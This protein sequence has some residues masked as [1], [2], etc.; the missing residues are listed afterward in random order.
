GSGRPGTRGGVF[1]SD[2]GGRVHR[3]GPTRAPITTPSGPSRGGDGGGQPNRGHRPRRSGGS[4]H[5]RGPRGG[6]PMTLRIGVDV[7]G[8]S[9]RLRPFPGPAELRI[10]A[11][12]GA[13]GPEAVGE[14]I[15]YLLDRLVLQTGPPAEIG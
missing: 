11:E 8:T 7:G 9:I 4:G 10:E 15:G 5:A 14:R 2:P 3:I 6:A 12:T 1:P 13:T